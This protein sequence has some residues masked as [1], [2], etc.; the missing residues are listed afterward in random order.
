MSQAE[1]PSEAPAGSAGAVSQ[2]SS[3]VSGPLFIQPPSPHGSSNR[4]RAGKGHSYTPAE[5]T[6]RLRGLERVGDRCDWLSATS[7]TGTPIPDNME[8][9]PRSA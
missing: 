3:P 8:E 7:L 1:E 5:R 4:R 2:E 6:Q 9:D